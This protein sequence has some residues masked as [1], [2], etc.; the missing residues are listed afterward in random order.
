MDYLDKIMNTVTKEVNVLLDKEIRIGVTGLSRGGKSAL[1]TS[2]VNVISMFGESGIGD[3]LPRFKAYDKFNISYGGITSS[4]MMSIKRFPYEDAIDSLSSNPPQWPSP[5]DGISEIRLEIKYRDEKWYSPIS[6]HT[7]YID[8]WDYP[9]EWLMDLLLLDLSYDEFSAKVKEYTEKVSS[10]VNANEWIKLGKALD[11]VAKPEVTILK[12]VV[13]EYTNWLISCKENDLAFIVP[14]RFVLPGELKGAPILEFVPWVWDK[15][16]SYEKESLYAELKN[17]YDAYKQEVV[18][19]FYKNC[20]AKIDRQLVL[21]DCL[22]ALKVGEVGFWDINNSFDILM[23][24]F[25]FGSSNFLTRLFAPRIDKVLFIGTKSDLVTNDQHQNML[26]MLKS[27]VRRSAAR[28][29]SDG[30]NCE[31]MVLSSVKSTECVL[32]QH[33]GKEQQVLVCNDEP[34]KAVF[35]GSVPPV[36]QDEWVEGYQNKF[37]LL[38]PRPPRITPDSLIPSFNI[39]LLLEYIIGDKL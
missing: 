32:T 17:R 2:L 39:D 21:V 26:S 4:H 13:A 10:V 15:V 14:G 18:Q 22:K 25:K 20:F 31:Y 34:T 11:L 33:Q 7:I 6:T 12:K 30:A 35:P 16:D 27:M 36:W 24:N 3:K 9:G 23:Q 38:N 28:V 5:T 37:K 8:I 1:I 29:R 19:K